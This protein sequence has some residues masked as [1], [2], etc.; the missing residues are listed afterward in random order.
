LCFKKLKMVN[1]VQ[2][3]NHVHNRDDGWI[4]QSKKV[5]SYGQNI[6]NIWPVWCNFTGLWRQLSRENNPSEI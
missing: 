5:V 4:L 6:V 2:N 3:K 1:N